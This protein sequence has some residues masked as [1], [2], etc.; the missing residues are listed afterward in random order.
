M[1]RIVIPHLDDLGMCRAGNAA[2]RTLADAGVVTCGSVM[3]PCPW[4]SEIAAWA[5]C[6]KTLDLGV[7]L[8][9]TSEWQHYRWRPLTGASPASGLVDDDGF[10]PRDVAGLAARVVPEAAEAELRAQIERALAAGL[11]PTHIDAHMAAAM[12][13]S[14]LD[15]HVRLAEEYGVF[16]VLP[17]RIRFAPDAAAYAATLAVLEARN[18]PLVD[19][20]RGTIPQTGEALA[21]G[22]RETLAGLP[23][24]VTHLALHAVEPGDF[25]AISPLHAPWREAEWSLLRSGGFTAMLRQADIATMGLREMQARWRA[26][27]GWG[28]AECGGAPGPPSNGKTDPGLALEM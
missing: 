6:E 21:A 28:L 24:G 15:A 20:I 12:L 2:F 22:W 13:P 18:R 27:S 11:R 23:E 8:T 7:H 4:F 26:A 17:R 3:V 25:A 5:T 16:P 19:G 10:M 9:L 1:A 14:L